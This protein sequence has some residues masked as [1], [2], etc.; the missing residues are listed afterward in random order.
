MTNGHNMNGI[1]GTN[2]FKFTGSVIDSLGV[3]LAQI[4]NITSAAKTFGGA[5]PETL[6]SIKNN[7]VKSYAAQSRCVIAEDYDVLV[8]QIFPA[9]DDVY[10]YGGETKKIPEYGRVYLVIKPKTG[11]SLSSVSKNYIKESLQDYRI[12]SIDVRIEDPD[13]LKVEVDT[14]V[15]YDNKKSAKDS[16][17]IRATVE[18]ALN[19]YKVSTAIPKFG[20]AFRYS[21]VVGIIDDS[22]KAITRNQT[23]MRMRKD[24]RITQ[25]TFATYQ[26]EYG[27]EIEDHCDDVTVYSTGFQLELEGRLDERIFRFE[28]D[29]KTTRSVSEEDNRQ[30]GNLYAFYFNEFNE[31]IRV[32]FY[33]NKFNQ[34]VVVDVQGDDKEASPIWYS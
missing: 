7:A 13:I 32:S 11:D 27:Q 10:V 26:L 23:T 15:F 9:T 1:Q 8:R 30:I 18:D 33:R 12:A 25:N 2:N 17:T 34:L 5:D 16:T 22:D 6:G 20:G 4:G 31:K 19:R 29:P 24:L 3:R 28:N 21:N 14:V